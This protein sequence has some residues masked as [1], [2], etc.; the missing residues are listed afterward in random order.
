MA[1]FVVT[2]GGGFIGSHVCDAIVARGD[3]VVCVD[4]FLTGRPENIAQLEHDPGFELVVADV[5]KEI[6]VDGAV[7]VVMHLASPASP[8]EYLKL[9]FESMDVSSLGTRH[10]LELARAHDARFFLASTS[11]VYGDPLVHPQPESYWGNVNPI[12]PRAVYDEAKRFAETLTMAYHRYHDVNTAIVRIF[13]TFGPRLR[14]ADGRVVSNFLVQAMREEP[15]TIYGDGSQTRSFCFVEDEVRG[16]LALVDSDV[17][18]PVN[19]GNPDSEFTMAQLANLVIEVTGSSSS[20]V[21]EPLP[22]DDPKQRKPDISRAREL[23]GWS[24]TIDLRE[25]LRRTYAWYEQ[26][27][28]RGR[29]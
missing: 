17:H 15:I 12:G 13:N 29:L 4:N 25:G 6:P 26:E 5:S 10:A 16:L 7:D 9:P 20:I 21:Y 28:A 3:T 2:G 18:E 27:A 22:T 24:P 11:E 1:R 14:P 8:P 19:I 23:L